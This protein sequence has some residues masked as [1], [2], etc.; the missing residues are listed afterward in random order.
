MYN[1]EKKYK[2]YKSKYFNLKQ[3]INKEGGGVEIET[4]YDDL[5]K[6][7]LYNIDTIGR[8]SFQD[9]ENK[10]GLLHDIYQLTIDIFTSLCYHTDNKNS[11]S[12]TILNNMRTEDDKRIDQ[13]SELLTKLTSN[14]YYESIINK[15]IKLN[16]DKLL[17]SS[18]EHDIKCHMNANNTDT[19]TKY[20]EKYKDNLCMQSL[21]SYLRVYLIAIHNYIYNNYNEY[22][23][24]IELCRQIR[25]PKYFGSSPNVFYKYLNTEYDNLLASF[26]TYL[27]T[28]EDT[29]DTKSIE[30]TINILIALCENTSNTDSLALLL[31]D[32]KQD[33]EKQD[34][35]KQDIE[36]QDIEKQDIEKQDIVKQDIVKQ[37]I[38]RQDN[39]KRIN[40]IMDLFEKL[41][42]VYKFL[43]VIQLNIITDFLSQD[44]K[45]VSQYIQSKINTINSYCNLK[46]CE[47]PT[48]DLRNFLRLYIVAIYNY[49]KTKYED[50]SSKSLC[51]KISSFITNNWVFDHIEI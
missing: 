37:D 40:D 22:I 35:E 1:Y 4:Y 51:D 3:L 47:K 31:Y 32:N 6:K 41:I 21:Q 8:I 9:T 12:L 38:E 5:L 26:N 28:T 45:L 10:L 27:D 49:I 18:T 50:N 29:E 30:L 42:E 48:S 17:L 15:Q 13:L 2:K 44:S 36:K 19:F 43:S 39:D 20:L 16:H 25:Q 11:L 7:F 46:K 23:N 33:I 34:I 14:K 24:F